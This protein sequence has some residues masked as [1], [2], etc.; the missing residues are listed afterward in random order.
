MCLKKKKNMIQKK[1]EQNYNNEYLPTI[2]IDKQKF[3]IFFCFLKI[4]I[5]FYNI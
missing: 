4:Y 1:N 3:D 2:P 5:C